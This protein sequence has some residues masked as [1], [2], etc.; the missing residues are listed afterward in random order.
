MGSCLQLPN[1]VIDYCAN[2]TGFHL[3]P[4]VRLD[5]GNAI[6]LDICKNIIIIFMSH[7]LGYVYT[8]ISTDLMLNQSNA[9]PKIAATLL[10]T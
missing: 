4:P 7:R 8:C 1:T 6:P 5:P 9:K 2:R 10:L 3:P